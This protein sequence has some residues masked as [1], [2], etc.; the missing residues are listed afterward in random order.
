MM[1]FNFSLTTEFQLLP[2]LG[3]SLGDH[4]RLS[5]TQK[6]NLR[7]G[8]G[9]RDLRTSECCLCS[10]RDR[11]EAFVDATLTALRQKLAIV[12]DNVLSHRI[13]QCGPVLSVQCVG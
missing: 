7:G 4:M 5:Q 8:D 9:V 13:S 2:P 12:G 1:L 10:C 11:S 3:H 6:V